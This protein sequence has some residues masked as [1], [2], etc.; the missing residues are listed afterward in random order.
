MQSYFPCIKEDSSKN[1]L[2]KLLPHLTSKTFHWFISTPI[3]IQP[4]VVMVTKSND[5]WLLIGR[6]PE[7]RWGCYVPLL[8]YTQTIGPFMMYIS[9]HVATNIKSSWWKDLTISIR[10]LFLRVFININNFLYHAVQWFI[11]IYIAINAL[12]YIR[13]SVCFY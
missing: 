1:L 6:G 4:L 2:L 7:A 10:V 9:N 11:Y 13:T 3:L 12:P 5:Q 8:A